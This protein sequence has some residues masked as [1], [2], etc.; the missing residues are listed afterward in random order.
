M[1]KC[2]NK[3]ALLELLVKTAQA[4]ERVWDQEPLARRFDMLAGYREC[5]LLLGEDDHHDGDV[6]LVELARL[7]PKIRSL[8][9]PLSHFLALVLPIERKYSKGLRDH[10]FLITTDDAGL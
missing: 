8:D 10:E 9:F 3:T 4:I 1:K 5:L 2:K 7:G 6:D